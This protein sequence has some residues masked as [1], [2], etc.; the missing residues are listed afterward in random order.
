MA[1]RTERTQAI[2]N[3]L[4]NKT[5]TAQQVAKMVN[6]FV[7]KGQENATNGEKLEIFLRSLR[8]YIIDRV[9]NAEANPQIETLR[10]EI[11]TLI[12]SDFKEE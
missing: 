12:D 6:A 11:F 8:Q 9:K 5:A 4:I 3:A 7:P 10:T 1:T 2:A